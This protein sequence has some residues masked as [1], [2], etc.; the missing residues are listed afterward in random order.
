M[1]DR[2]QET[3]LERLA[4]R[5]GVLTSYRD[6]F[7]N[8]RKPPPETLVAILRLLGAEIERPDGAWEALSAAERQRWLEFA[9]P[10]VAAWQGSPASLMLRLPESEAGGAVRCHLELESGEKKVWERRFEQLRTRSCRVSDG[11]RFVAKRL[12]LPGGLPLGCHRLRIEAGS[13]SA[14]TTVLA[15]PKQCYLPPGEGLW[16]VFLPLYALHSGSSWGAGDL[17]DLEALSEWARGL[18]GALV[19]TLPLLAAF[20]DEPFEYSPYVPASRLFWNEFYVDPR[21]TPEWESSAA[22]RERWTAIEEGGAIDEL[23]RSPLV[24]YRR[25]AELKREVLEALADGLSHDGIA[26]LE[27]LASERPD[28]GSY[29]A[30]RATVETRRDT[31]QNWPERLRRGD[32]QPSDYDARR[33]LY[34][35]YAQQTAERQLAEL[36]RRTPDPGLYLDLPLGVHPGGYD[37]WRAP[38]AFALGAAGGAP[39]DR[40]FTKGQN[41]GFAPLNPRSLRRSGYRYWIA[42]LDH[43]LRHA[44]VLRLDHVMCL[45]RLYW[46]PDGASATDGTYVQ[47]YAQEMYAAVAIASARRR[48]W[49]IGED[50]GTVPDYVRSRLAERGIDGMYVAQ[51][52]FRDNPTALRPIPH[53]AVASLNTHD[54]PTFAA[55]WQGRDIDDQVEMGLLTA[56]EAAEARDHRA[57]VKDA[58]AKRLGV[59]ENREQVMRACLKKLAA[60]PA[61]AVLVN[62]E[63]LWG[64]TAPQNTPGAVDRPNWRRRSGLSLEQMR[65]APEVLEPLR[66]VARARKENAEP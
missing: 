9:P 14:Q 31:W 21:R 59:S 25:Q 33:R 53:N 17:S 37:V 34:H 63:D 44:G 23:R 24:D 65:E 61:R 13:R 46:V 26:R 51:F 2:P 54:T 52:S 20:L 4:R 1:T 16:G 38:E 3:P 56:D 18:G 29:A 58:V 19:G 49:I 6:G 15:A 35:L 39:P 62:L 36:A 60:S 64:E 22:A 45:H 47:S 28:L 7:Q 55:Y 10:A 43:H 27:A 50:L 5:Y 40:F 12:P 42:C 57:R 66:A 11:S 32:L 8:V 41:W 30:F 48:A